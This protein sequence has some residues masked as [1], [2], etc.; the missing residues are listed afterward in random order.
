MD[1]ISSERM[2]IETSNYDLTHDKVKE[3]I[4]SSQREDYA[5]IGCS[6]EKIRNRDLLEDI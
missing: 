6:T 4:M 3:K 5:D 2:V 1:V